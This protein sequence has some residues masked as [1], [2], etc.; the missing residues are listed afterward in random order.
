MKL[1]DRIKGIFGG[2]GAWVG[3]LSGRGFLGNSFELGRIEDGFQRELTLDSFTMQR[4]PA[5]AGAKHLYRSAFAQLW[6]DHHRFDALGNVE[7]ITTSAASRVLLTPNSYETGSEFNARVV[8]QWITHGSVLLLATRNDRYEVSSIHI[9]PTGSWQWQIDEDTKEI[10]YMI[11][12]A[13]ALLTPV[14]ATVIVPARDVVHLRWATPRHPLIGESPLQAAGVAAGIHTALSASQAAF[15]SQMRR[16]SGVLSTEMTLSREQMTTLK[17]AWDDQSKRLNQGGVPILANGLKWQ[18]LSIT[19]ADA[20]VINT[21]KM[22]NDEIFRAMGVP[23]PLLG[24]LENATLSN[25]EQ[26]VQAWLAFSLGGLIER[27]ERAFDRLFGF[28]PRKDRVEMS[29]D[30][31]LRS[32]LAGRMTALSS[33]ITG[34]VMSPNEARRKE[35]L[36]PVAGGDQVFL[37]R[38]NTPVDVLTQLAAAELQAK[39]APPPPPPAPVAEEK[40]EE[41]SEEEDAAKGLD[42]EDYANLAYLT[43]QKAMQ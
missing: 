25:T 12:E 1:F 18:P 13:G 23:P 27:Y 11:N 22:T 5:I 7:N 4:I 41:V 10:Y 9:V 35:G 26:L 20:E 17:G 42:E 30:A 28:D 43:I 29:V 39:L 3:P 36:S 6:A 24:A 15:F 40:P 34:G 19:S 8:D 2:E 31:L 16:P 38:Q 14:D 37:Q 32:D 33:G 21:L